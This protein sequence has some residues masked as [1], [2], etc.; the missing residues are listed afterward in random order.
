[1]LIFGIDKFMSEC[2]ALVNF[3][4]N[5]VA[6]LFVAKWDKGLDVDRVRQVLNKE[7]VPDLPDEIDATENPLSIEST[8]LVGAYTADF[9]H[10]EHAPK[11][12][13]SVDTAAEIT[14]QLDNG[15]VGSNGQHHAS[16]GRATQP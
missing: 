12:E 4:G 7:Q 6:T 8:K 9:H 13:Y 3:I 14:G 16:A 5:A 2:R 1:M 11:P 10:H 15:D